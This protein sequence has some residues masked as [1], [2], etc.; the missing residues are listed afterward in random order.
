MTPRTFRMAAA[1]GAIFGVSLTASA[2]LTF[3]GNGRVVPYQGRLERNG[4]PVSD[5]RPHAMVFTFYATDTSNVTTACWTSS[6]Q[7]VTVFNGQFSLQLG[8]VSDTC[9]AST[10]KDLNVGITVQ[11]PDDTSAVALQGRQK[12]LPVP[13]AISG[14]AATDFLV[15]G[16]LGIGKRNP[17]AALHV[18][19]KWGNQTDPLSGLGMLYNTDTGSS[20]HASLLLRVASSA[21]GDPFIAFDIANEQ[22]WTAGI[23]NSDGNKFKISSV[24]NVVDSNTRLTID[25]GGNVTINTAGATLD[26]ASGVKL[27]LD[28]FGTGSRTLSF[29]RDPNDEGNSGK[30]IYKPS[31][32]PGALYIVGPGS[33][34]GSRF[35]HLSDNVYVDGN[36][37]AAN[38]VHDDCYWTGSLC[39][40]QT[41]GNGYF[42]AGFNP[43]LNESCGGLGN[44]SDF[45]TFRLYCCHL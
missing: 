21:A 42:M 17:T 35:I 24:Y 41:C 19:Q 15:Q 1:A 28:E 31:W 43:E 18:E 34:V 11:G 36:F 22:G 27:G 32:D 14:P 39:G 9:F 29:R 30:I 45:G 4:A 33:G 7:S 12:L 16:N 10:V 23:D 3:S 25:T 13:Y 37:N 38:N 40:Q 20:S 5:P 2:V 8:P 44:D 26:L 6:T